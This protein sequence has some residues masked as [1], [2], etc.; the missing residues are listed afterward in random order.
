MKYFFFAIGILLVMIPS[1]HAQLTDEE[2]I[3]D[4]GKNYEESVILPDLY[5]IHNTIVCGTVIA[6]DPDKITP[7]PEQSSYME[8]SSYT[9]NAEKYFKN[10]NPNPTIDA[11][12]SEDS[13]GPKSMIPF[14][15]GQI[16]LF[17]IDKIDEKTSLISP[18]SIKVKTCKSIH[19]QS[20]LKQFKSGIF[21]NEIICKE[22]LQLIVNNRDHPACVKNT[23][24]EILSLRNYVSEQIIIGIPD[25][26]PHIDNAEIQLMFD[27]FKDRYHI[28][29]I[30]Y[31][32]PKIILIATNVWGETISLV[33][34][35]LDDKVDATLTCN[36][37]DWRNR[38][39]IT[40][41]VLD[42]LKNV[43]CFNPTL[44][45]VRK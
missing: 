24:L 8:G 27:L 32:G 35:P 19:L 21:A 29:H 38:E 34:Q 28:S 17:Y 4:F 45:E 10:S 14:E 36:H 5:N 39:V 18:D 43:N 13:N 41:N 26:L 6:K 42:Y 25:D 16:G 11:L 20:P 37:V 2:K 1:V 30:S 7:I 22:G 23:S 9:I 33:M 15:I 44:E 31:V 12:G 40:E 3:S